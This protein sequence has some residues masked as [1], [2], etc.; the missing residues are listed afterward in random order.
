MSYIINLS[1]K[2]YYKWIIHTL[3]ILND[4]ILNEL[5]YISLDNNTKIID[6][7]II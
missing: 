1:I 7:F 2:Y 5:A 3:N 6:A 4:V